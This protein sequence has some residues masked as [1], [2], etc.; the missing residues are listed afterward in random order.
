MYGKRTASFFLAGI[1]LVVPILSGCTNK[2]TALMEEYKAQGIAQMEEGDYEGAAVTFQTGLDQ[3]VGTIGAEEMDL[4]YY[5]ALALYL[6]GDSEG[7]LEVYTALIDYDED[8]WEAYYLR[9]NVYLDEGK[10]NEALSDYA[11]AVSLNKDDVDLYVHICD[12]LAGAGLEEE[13][14]TYL[15][16]ALLMQPSSAEDYYDLGEIC[17]VTGDYDSAE[18]YLKQ[19]Q[20]MGRDD[21]LLLLGSIYADRG[22]TDSAREMYLSYLDLDADNAEALCGLGEMALADGDYEDAVSW[23][24]K[25]FATE[26]GP[27]MSEVVTNLVAAYEYS[28]DFESAYEVAGEYLESHTDEALEREYTFLAT[29]VGALP[30]NL[31]EEAEEEAREDETETSEEEESDV[32]EEESEE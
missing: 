31:E 2:R 5:K 17:Y 22:D 18:S 29:R 16:T 25:A 12:N 26:E 28:G 23:L 27:S 15:S 7:S 11:E 14:Q 6:A 19:A 21:T 9:G 4:T 3:S 20:E 8:N 13:M 10:D 30:D 1:V 24:T 32:Y